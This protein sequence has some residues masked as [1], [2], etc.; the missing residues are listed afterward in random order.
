MMN[1]LR[2]VDAVLSPQASQF[3]SMLWRQ[4]LGEAL[5]VDRRL[6][7]ALDRLRHP[8]IAAIN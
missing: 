2:G 5:P 7:D 1:V 3:L 6:T 8:S 4:A